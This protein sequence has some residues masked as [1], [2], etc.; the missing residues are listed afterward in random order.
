[1]IILIDSACVSIP[2]GGRQRN[3]SLRFLPRAFSNAYHSY[4]FNVSRYLAN[5]SSYIFSRF[6]YTHVHTR[7]CFA[8]R[9][10]PESLRMIRLTLQLLTIPQRP[11][12]LGFPW[13]NR[14]R[15]QESWNCAP[16]NS[17]ECFWSMPSQ[18][19]LINL[20]AVWYGNLLNRKYI[21]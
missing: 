8:P 15:D 18:R 16:R 17:T 11:W 7:I 2:K 12:T 5:I 9:G 6:L 1:M 20:H 10:Y 3:C 14:R 19:S 13:G 4:K 21:N